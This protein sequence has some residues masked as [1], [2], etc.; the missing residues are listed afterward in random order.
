MSNHEAFRR[1]IHTAVQATVDDLADLVE[2]RRAAHAPQLVTEAIVAMARRI[3][4]ALYPTEDPGPSGDEPTVPRPAL[5]TL[6]QVAALAAEESGLPVRI[7]VSSDG[8]QVAGT[9]LGR[10]SLRAVSWHDMTNSPTPVLSLAVTEV[11]AELTPS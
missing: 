7:T 3:A 5:H 2:R 10:Q 9:H 6:L 11:I 1:G 8:L 4:H